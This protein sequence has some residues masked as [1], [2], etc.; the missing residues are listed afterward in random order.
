MLS[1]PPDRPHPYVLFLGHENAYVRTSA[2]VAIAEAVEHWPQ[3]VDAT[4]HT[5]QEFYREKVRLPFNQ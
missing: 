1:L 5:L 2:A 4:I 3:S